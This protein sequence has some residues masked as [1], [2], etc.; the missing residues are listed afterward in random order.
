MFNSQVTKRKITDYN[1]FSTQIKNKKVG[2]IVLGNVS[3]VYRIKNK[4]KK[5]QKE[6]KI[7]QTILL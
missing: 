5:K 3:L 4:Y 6:N 7:S 1:H 2:N